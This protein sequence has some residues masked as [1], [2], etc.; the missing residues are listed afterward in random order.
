MILISTCGLLLRLHQAEITAIRLRDGA[1]I[2]A[3]CHGREFTAC[4]PDLE[5][6][7]EV[8][9]C[10]LEGYERHVAPMFMNAAACELPR[11][12]A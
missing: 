8:L 5:T 4:G 12:D 10:Q 1:E 9:M 2:V 7:F 6:A 11:K 3:R